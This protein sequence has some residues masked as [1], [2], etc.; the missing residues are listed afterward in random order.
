MKDISQANK[1]LTVDSSIT[2]K[3]KNLIST[4][5]LILAGIFIIVYSCKI[6]CPENLNSILSVI[7]IVGFIMS[8][9]GIIMIVFPSKKLIYKPTGEKIKKQVCYFDS[10]EENEVMEKLLKGNFADLKI[11]AANNNSSQ[12]KAEIY[13]TESAE[14]SVVQLQ[15]YVPYQYEP[16]MEPYVSKK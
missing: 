13:F 3:R 1:L 2:K 14:F 6:N 4:I 5:L 11:M 12:L 10:K 15:K 16:I 7:V 8:I 9:S